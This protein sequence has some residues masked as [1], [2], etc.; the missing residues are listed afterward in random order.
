MG[1]NFN[2]QLLDPASSH[3]PTQACVG[4]QILNT[5]H[6]VYNPST[7]NVDSVTNSIPLAPVNNCNFNVPIESWFPSATITRFGYVTVATQSS[8]QYPPPTGTRNIGSPPPTNLVPS[9]A[10]VATRLLAVF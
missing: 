10:L 2:V 7:G 1:N 4:S 6:W 9:A 5:L 3:N 8:H